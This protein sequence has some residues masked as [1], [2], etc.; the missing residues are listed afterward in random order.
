MKRDVVNRKLWVYGIS[1]HG[2]KI[3]DDAEDAFSDGNHLQ[4]WFCV[5]SGISFY[6]EIQIYLKQESS[7][8]KLENSYDWLWA[9]ASCGARRR[10]LPKRLS[11][12]VFRGQPFYCL[13]IFVFFLSMP[14]EFI[15]TENFSSSCLYSFRIRK[16]NRLGW[17][18]EKTVF[19][20]VEAGWKQRE[21]FVVSGVQIR[22]F[23]LGLFFSNFKAELI[24]QK[25]HF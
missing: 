21:G 13:P 24:D 22:T 2:E 12:I 5:R 19:T 10:A 7:I 1:K 11:S 25:I 17:E 4:Y 23:W 20:K 14:R 16:T 3:D 18:R 15:D 9:G 8:F 6:F